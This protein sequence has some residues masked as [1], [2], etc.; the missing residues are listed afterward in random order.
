MVA[1]FVRSLRWIAHSDS[2]KLIVPFMFLPEGICQYNAL[3]KFIHYS[4]NLFQLLYRRS[5]L[6]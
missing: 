6:F 5:P 1:V 4:G 2:L 3:R